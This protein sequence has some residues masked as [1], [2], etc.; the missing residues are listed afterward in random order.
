MFKKTALI[1]ALMNA[2]GESAER[3]QMCLTLIQAGVDIN[4]QN[5]DGQTALMMAANRGNFSSVKL[6]IEMGVN[7]NIQDAEGKIAL[8]YARSHSQDDYFWASN[9]NYP[10]VVEILRQR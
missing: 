9:V 2:I 8:D 3:N 5:N 7:V 10:A 6:L 1:A 4:A